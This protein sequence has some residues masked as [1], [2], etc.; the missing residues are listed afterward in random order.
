MTTRNSL[1]DREARRS[2]LE[3]ALAAMTGKT[4]KLR[5]MEQLR[6]ARSIDG[7]AGGESGRLA[8]FGCSVVK[9]TIGSIEVFSLNAPSEFALVTEPES[10]IA[11]RV[12]ASKPGEGW[13]YVS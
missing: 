6:G 13:A 3:V 7:V 12:E 2:S 5:M 11:L 9:G 8:R 10:S 4:A 1:M